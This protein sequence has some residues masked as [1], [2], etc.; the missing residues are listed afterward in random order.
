MPLC[1]D[2]LNGSQLYGTLLVFF[3][4]CKELFVWLSLLNSCNMQVL[5]YNAE[6]SVTHRVFVRQLCLTWTI[7]WW[8]FFQVSFEISCIIW[9]ECR[10]AVQ[11][12]LWRNYLGALLSK[13][14]RK[15]KF[16]TMKSY[17]GHAVWY[18]NVLCHRKY[19]NHVVNP[20]GAVLWR[21]CLS[22]S[23]HGL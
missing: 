10:L 13:H 20:R 21:A 7:P 8:M 9:S 19:G 4:N 3:M 12:Q 1:W 11:I 5:A 15:H 14:T 18:L 2:V 6:Y 23:R 17:A 22:F 16:M